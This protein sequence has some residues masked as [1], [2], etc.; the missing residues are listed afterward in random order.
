MGYDPVAYFTA[1]KPQKGNPQFSS[2]YRGATYYFV[3]AENKA[4]SDAEPA[5]YEPQFG[6]YCAYAASRG[7]TASI[8]PDAFEILHGR[9]LLQYSKEALDK[10]NA[11]PEKN[12]RK[13]DQNWPALVEKHG[14]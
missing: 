10:F 4:R 13:A 8:S 1:N 6:G 5:K 7:Y 14:R 12:L 3:S 9:L 11:D 2:Q